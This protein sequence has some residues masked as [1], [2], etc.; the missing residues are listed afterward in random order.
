MVVVRSYLLRQLLA[1]QL[2]ELH[3]LA[4]QHHAVLKSLAKQHHLGNQR[5]AG[6]NNAG[7]GA[8]VIWGRESMHTLAVQG[9]QLQHAGY[10]TTELQLLLCGL[11]SP[12]SS[13]TW[14]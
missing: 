4:R 12:G 1:G 2:V 7:C 10:D 3:H 5:T 14:A 11:T 13:W 9:V 8:S 6:S